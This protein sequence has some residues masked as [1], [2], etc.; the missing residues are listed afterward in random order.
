MEFTSLKQL[1]QKLI[2]AFNVKKRLVK[3]SKYKHITN[4]NIWEYLA[5]TKW[6]QANNLSLPDMINDIITVD[7]DEIQKYLEA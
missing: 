5:N 4:E 6:R 7:L 2:P 1:Y 3:N